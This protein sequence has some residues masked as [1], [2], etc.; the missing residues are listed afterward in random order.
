MKDSKCIFCK[1]VAGEAPAYKIYEDKDHLA[2]LDL[3]PTAEGQT[4]VIPKKHLD[5]FFAKAEDEEL[6]SLM[7]AAKKV[8]NIIVEKLPARRV[9]LVFEGLDVNHLHAKLFPNREIS[10]GLGP[11]ASDSELESIQKRLT[12]QAV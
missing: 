9:I 4:L 7:L 3:F 10:P 5:S 6:A 8:A 1:I 11:K 2:F 12:K